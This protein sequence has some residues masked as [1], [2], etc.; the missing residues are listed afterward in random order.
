[1][2]MMVMMMID[3]GLKENCW[4]P[5]SFS[6]GNLSASILK[7]GEDEHNDGI[8][9]D[10]DDNGIDTDDGDDEEEDE[11]ND[12]I[13]DGDDDGVPLLFL[14]HIPIPSSVNWHL[15]RHTGYSPR[16]KNQIIRRHTGYS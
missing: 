11:G 2:M 4:Q 6:A 3:D 12:G 15:H 10:G 7:G 13:D 1:M 9:G 16:I 5:S 14:A 8:G